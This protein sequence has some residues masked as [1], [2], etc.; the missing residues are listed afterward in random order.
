MADTVT[1]N[2]SFV[3]PEVG[4]S[5]DTWG[6]KV[7]TNMDLLDA[8]IFAAQPVGAITMYGGA[9]APTGWLLCQG[10]AVSRTTYAKL[11]AVIG[12]AFGIGDN[13]ATF[14][15][16]DMRGQFARGVNTAA[17]GDDPSR[18]LGT[19][20]AGLVES[21][22]HAGTINLETTEHVHGVNGNTGTVSS[23]HTHSVNINTGNESADHAHYTTIS[24]ATDAQ[25]SH[26]H[27]G[28][29]DRGPTQIQSGGYASYGAVDGVTDSAGNHAHNFSGGAW[30]G[31][32]SAA[33]YHN[34][35][36]NTGG[37]SVNHSHAINFISGGRSAGHTHTMVNAT[38]GTGTDT[39]PTNVALNFI[40][41]TGL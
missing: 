32:R 40:I 35:A 10:Q 7:N 28:V 3:K 4:G 30:S 2:Y 17:T 38:Y 33:H 5:D 29:A 22:T 34:V 19:K 31:G 12:T 1:L 37:I 41:K 24:G 14:N 25:G 23:D 26:A 15:V 39:R 21:H 6:G 13:V 20:Q 9:A 8:L 16:P 36:G 11:F 18:V 27:G